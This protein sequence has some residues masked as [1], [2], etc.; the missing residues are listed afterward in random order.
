VFV[1]GQ[2]VS[3][4][5]GFEYLLNGT[6]LLP[7][8]RFTGTS[9]RTM[10]ETF[11]EGENLGLTLTTRHS[12]DL[13]FEP[14]QRLRLTLR[15]SYMEQVFVQPE[16]GSSVATAAPTGTT[17]ASTDDRKDV[18]LTGGVDLAYQM[19]RTLTATLT[20]THTRVDSSLRGLD[21][22]TNVVRLGISA[23]FE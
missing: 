17:G 23:R 7:W 2:T 15:A 4:D 18:T 14:A 12:A 21:F 13:T 11:V 9:N 8:G 19:T 1:D 22:S 6:Y 20:Y 16:S 10:Q 3:E 5:K